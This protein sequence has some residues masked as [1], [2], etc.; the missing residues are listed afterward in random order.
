MPI[1]LRTGLPGHGKT[2]FALKEIE[3]ERQKS[4]RPVYYHGIPGLTLAWN[5]IGDPDRWYELEDGAIIVIDE[6]QTVFRPRG[7]SSQVPEKV[8]R[9]EVHRHRGHDIHLIT[10]HPNLIDANIR[11]LVDRHVHVFRGWGLASTTR[12]EW[13]ECQNP[14]SRGARQDCTMKS[15]HRF[16]THI[17]GWYESSTLHTVQPRLPWKLI[18]FLLFCLLG[19]AYFGHTLYKSFGSDGWRSR[20]APGVPDPT[21]PPLASSGSGGSTGNSRSVASSP[22]SVSTPQELARLLTPVVHSIPASAPLYQAKWLVVQ[23]FPIVQGCVSDKDRCQ[24]YTQ[25]G[26]RAD[27]DERICRSLVERAAFDHTRPPTATVQAAPGTAPASPGTAPAGAQPQLIPAA[28]TA[29]PRTGER[30]RV[31]LQRAS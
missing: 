15:S 25:Q 6:A 28:V 7:T 16:P 19:M 13:Q 31:V 11:R 24:C 10:Q 29:T 2:L 26:T 8:S 17:Y 27:V 21:V 4:G 12:Y 30:P 18:C 9:F 3:E 22:T 14:Q 1:T 5:P 20:V 23:S